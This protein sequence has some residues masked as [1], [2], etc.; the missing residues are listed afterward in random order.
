MIS[1]I[2]SSSKRLVHLNIKVKGT[3][4][5]LHTVRDKSLG[6][7]YSFTEEAESFFLNF[8]SPPL[9]CLLGDTKAYNNE[10]YLECS[11]C[12]FPRRCHVLLSPFAN[13]WG[14]RYSSLE[15]TLN[16]QIRIKNRMLFCLEVTVINVALNSCEMNV[17]V[18]V[19]FLF[20]KLSQETTGIK[21]K[22]LCCFYLFI[23]KA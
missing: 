5:Y 2:Y 15:H 19:L 14:N 4:S 16:W 20:F 3:H 12:S 17:V 21:N 6:C 1:L 23:L 10:A 22:H 13:S 11:S 8:F 9:C 18:I 7:Q